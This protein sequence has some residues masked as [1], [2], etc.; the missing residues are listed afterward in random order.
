MHAEHVR[1]DAVFDVSKRF[2]S[3]EHAQNL[4]QRCRNRCQC[5]RSCAA[6]S[7]MFTNRSKR[8]VIRF[9]RIPPKRAVDM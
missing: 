5:E 6:G 1:A 4:S 3:I 2:D 9:H 8:L 7:V